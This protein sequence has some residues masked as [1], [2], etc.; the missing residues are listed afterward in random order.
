MNSNKQD[1]NLQW[2]FGSGTIAETTP[3]N[4]FMGFFLVFDVLV[5]SQPTEGGVHYQLKALLIIYMDNVSQVKM[6]VLFPNKALCSANCSNFLICH[7]F[8]N[9]LLGSFLWKEQHHHVTPWCISVVIAWDAELCHTDY[10]L[11]MGRGFLD[12]WLWK[13][14]WVCFFSPIGLPHVHAAPKSSIH[15]R[16]RSSWVSNNTCQVELQGFSF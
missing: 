14:L 5:S 11:R 13:H 10:S 6:R 12:S 3:P 9:E 4:D 15:A 16:H 8:S 2:H 7:Y 1:F